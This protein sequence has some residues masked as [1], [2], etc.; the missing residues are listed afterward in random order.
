M[1]DECKAAIKACIDA[2]LAK[3]TRKANIEIELIHF[4]RRQ[5]YERND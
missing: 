1:M 4:I 2:E 3:D 5:L